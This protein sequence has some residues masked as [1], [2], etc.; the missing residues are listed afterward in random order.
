MRGSPARGALI[1]AAL[2]MLITAALILLP[3]A[4]QGDFYEIGDPL[5]VMGMPIIVLSTI[6]GA[7][8]V[9]TPRGAGA[10]AGGEAHPSTGIRQV[11][12][13]CLC[14]GAVLAVWLLLWG[15]GAISTP[16]LWIG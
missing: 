13:G 4:L 16:V 15:T 10:G 12:I 7:V 3:A 2:G 6:V 9:P 14:V 5:L 1:G 8:V 11:W